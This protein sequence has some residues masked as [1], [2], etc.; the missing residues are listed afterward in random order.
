[1]SKQH[2][3]FL[4]DKILPVVLIAAAAIGTFAILGPPLGA[5]NQVVPLW[6]KDFSKMCIWHSDTNSSG[7]EIVY[8]DEYHWDTIA[9]KGFVRSDGETAYNIVHNVWKYD[10]FHLFL[11]VQ[12]TTAGC[13]ILVAFNFSLLDST[14]QALR[15]SSEGTAI[16]KTYDFSAY[17]DN[18]SLD[19]LPELSIDVI[20][21]DTITNDTEEFDRRFLVGGAIMGKN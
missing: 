19:F 11:N 15:D 16:K 6:G 1:M 20:V 10:G 12:P 17:F 2:K 5:E 9:M 3:K 13:S 7:D 14:Y 8:A 4:N 21:G 18:D